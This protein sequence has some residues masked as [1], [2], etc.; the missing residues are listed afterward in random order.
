MDALKA[1]P[2]S[3]G[4]SGGGSEGGS[5]SGG[6]AAGEV[7]FRRF[8]SFALAREEGLREAFDMFDRDRDGVISYEDLDLSLQHVTIC[9]PNT[10]CVLRCRQQVVGELL[11]RLD[12][13]GSRDVSFDEFRNYF[14]LLPQ[15]DAS[16]LVEYWLGASSSGS[17]A[18]MGTRVAVQ[19]GQRRGSPWGHLF[20]GAVSGAASRTATA[21]LE[22]LRLA[23]MA[24]GVPAGARMDL[25][26]AEIVRSHGWRALYKGNGI[27]VMRSAPQ[28]AL[29][30]FNFDLYKALLSRG[31]AAGAT[32]HQTFLAAGLAG[33]TSCLLLYP[34][35]VAR[36]RLTLDT[37]GR[38]RGLA[39]CLRTLVATEG[40]CALWRGLGPSLAAIFPEAA[41]TYGLHDLL[42]RNYK[43][44]RHEEPGIGASLAAGVAS[45]SMG[46]PNGFAWHF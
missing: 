22:T 40:M 30:F 13:D 6:G 5:G 10:R 16:M 9:C 7:G 35:D 38:Y 8:R 37:A 21:P 42:K 36:M 26:A 12:T 34:L 23:A 17:C 25:M 33:A 24:G 28:K 18:D 14:S 15:N 20:A 46:Q 32:L 44:L 41:I 1:D 11:R 2:G 27:N 31:S 39:H 3:E 45:A 4:Q 29:D 43:R 19:E